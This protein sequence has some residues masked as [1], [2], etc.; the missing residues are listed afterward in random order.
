MDDVVDA[1]QPLA[2][3]GAQETVRIRDDADHHDRGY[4]PSNDA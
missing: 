2:D 4:P 3:L 1:R